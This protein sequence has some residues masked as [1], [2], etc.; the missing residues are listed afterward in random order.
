MTD[1]QARQYSPLALAFVG[2]AVYEQLVRDELVIG[3]NMPVRK[4]HSLAVQKV[5]AEYQS[6]AVR[7][8]IDSERLTE[9]EQEIFKRG[10]N[11]GG[12]SAPKHS[13]VA[14]YRA[15]TGLECLFGYLHLTAQSER[16]KELYSAIGELMEEPRS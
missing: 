2:D 1:L 16:I 3:A 8:L 15:A 14:D 6:A 11:A 13:T 7:A 5:C 9:E 12:I 4:L 10:R